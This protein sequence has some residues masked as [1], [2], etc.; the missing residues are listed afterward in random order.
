MVGQHWLSFFSTTQFCPTGLMNGH[1]L[2]MANVTM[3]EMTTMTM[4][5]LMMTLLQY[6]R[7]HMSIWLWQVQLRQGSLVM[8]WSP[9][10]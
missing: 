6:L 10:S 3:K 8:I 7:K 1:T 4:T 2:T 9:S 5:S